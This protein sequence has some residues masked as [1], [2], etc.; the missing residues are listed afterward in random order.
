[1]DGLR[2]VLVVWEGQTEQWASLQRV[3]HLKKEIGTEWEKVREAPGRAVSPTRGNDRP[4]GGE[5][6][7]GLGI[8]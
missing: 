2:S 4:L 1:M 3:H 8:M 7:R 5:A 6:E